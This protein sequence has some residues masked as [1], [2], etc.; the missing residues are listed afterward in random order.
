ME[1]QA[2]AIQVLLVEDDGSIRALVSDFLREKGFEITEAEA[3]DEAIA[4]LDQRSFDL[5]Y[6]D[7]DLHG[8]VDGLKIAAYARSKCPTLPV[9]IT[10]G[11]ESELTS[12]L[13]ALEP[14][15]VFVRKP[16]RLAQI[17]E[18]L[19]HLLPSS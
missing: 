16:Y 12:R 5:V 13:A 7:V 15:A 10:S 1:R 17:L 19:R 3:G 11:F 14:A 18:A 8:P 4:L 6:S 9:L 2:T